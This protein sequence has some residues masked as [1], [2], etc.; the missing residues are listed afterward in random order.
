MY[1]GIPGAIKLHNG[2]LIAGIVE[3]MQVVAALGHVYDVL[4]VQGIICHLPIDRLLYSQAILIIH[5]TRCG[6]NAR[7][8]PPGWGPGG[9]WRLKAKKRSATFAF[10]KSIHGCYPEQLAGIS[11]GAGESNH[12]SRCGFIMGDG[13]IW[14]IDSKIEGSVFRE[15]YR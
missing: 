14:R 5:E 8:R 9:Q 4:A 6:V 2:R 10:S 1:I 7:K 13:N 11:I 15:Q 12:W 3:E